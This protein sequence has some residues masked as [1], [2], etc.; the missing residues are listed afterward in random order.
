MAPG[1]I[2]AEWLAET[3]ISAGVLAVSCAGRDR[4]DAALS[5]IAGVLAHGE[6]GED[7]ARLLE[8]GTGIPVAMWLGLEHNYRAGLA[9][10]LPEWEAEAAG[11]RA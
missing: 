7:T 1:E 9:A 8:A 4:R 5:V 6:L 11:S 3:N 10:G 2:L